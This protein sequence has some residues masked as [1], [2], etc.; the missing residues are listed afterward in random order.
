MSVRRGWLVIVLAA[1]PLAAHADTFERLVGYRCDARAGE[2]MVTYRGAWN[3]EGKALLATK[4]DTEW[5]PANLV[6]TIDDDHYGPSAVV[7]ARCVL[8]ETAYRI[9]LGANPQAGS[10]DRQ[11]GME[12]GGWFEVSARPD[13]PVFHHDFT[14]LCEF[15]AR[16]VTRLVFRPGVAEPTS[17]SVASEEFFK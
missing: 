16:V 7:E 15:R 13:S 12:I 14:R 10:M 1:S 8:H 17:T 6:R 5:D 9:R 11:C 4:T 3:D 2:L